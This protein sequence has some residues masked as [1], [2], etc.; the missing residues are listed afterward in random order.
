MCVAL[1]V[2]VG[3]GAPLSALAES[4][5]DKIVVG[6]RGDFDVY[7][8]FNKGRIA[9]AAIPSG[10]GAKYVCTYETQTGMKDEPHQLNANQLIQSI[11]T[12]WQ[13]DGDGYTC[14][15]GQDC[16]FVTKTN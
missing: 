16:S 11:G 3:G 7:G 8:F 4:C 15:L 9:S 14:Q 6:K 1:L 2:A 10:P 12:G 5:P 13:K